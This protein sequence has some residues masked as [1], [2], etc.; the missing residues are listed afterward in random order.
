MEDI[1]A[2]KQFIKRFSR[3]RI[4]EHWLIA[5]TFAILVVT[6]LSQK[7]YEAELS[8]WIVI[9][10]GGIDFVR[11]I[12]RSTGLFL[13]LLMMQH[14]LTAFFGVLLRRWEP[15][16]LINAKDFEDAIE[17]MKYYFGLAGRPARCDRYDYKQKFEYWGILTGGLLMIISGLTLWFP[18]PVS[19]VIP[20]AIIP[21]AKALHTNEASI[22]FVII[23]LWHIYNSIFSPE[24]FP[25]DTSIITGRI[26]KERLMKE[27]ALEYERMFGEKTDLPEHV[28]VKHKASLTKVI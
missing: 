27:H 4:A 19:R 1:T 12:H 17:N 8:R 26:S 7:Y 25:M 18:I 9:N 14:L 16:I 24:V 5:A 3:F 2:K 6:G 10:L 28:P 20:G 21:A 15:S 11:L 13:S 22:I 23:A